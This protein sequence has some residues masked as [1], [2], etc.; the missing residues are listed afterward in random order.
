M[1]FLLN[2]KNTENAIDLNI[3]NSILKLDSLLNTNFKNNKKLN[4][5]GTI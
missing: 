5:K 3:I 1:K 4:I 2:T